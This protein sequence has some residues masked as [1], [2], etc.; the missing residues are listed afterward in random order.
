MST[1]NIGLNTSTSSNGTLLQI[2]GLASNLDTNAIINALLAIDK[3]PVTRLTNQQSGLKAL[4]T[5]LTG[6]QTTLQ[7]LAANAQA[8][9][10][11]GLWA[12]S[13]TV[14]SSDPTRVSASTSSGAGVGGYQVSVTQLANSAQR[15]FT[16]ASPAADETVSIDG[17]YSTTIKAGES[18][19][20][21]VNGINADSG[22]PVYAAA[23]DSNHVV[24]SYRQTGAH[25]APNYIVL[26]GDTQNVL[27]DTGADRAGQDAQYSID[28][29]ATQ[30]SS[31]NTV[32][33]A[34]AGVTLTFNGVTTTSGPVT[35]NV[36]APAPNSTSIQAAVKTFVDSYNSMIDQL[37][38]QL[39]EKPS[40]SDPTVGTL[41]GDSELTDLMSQLRAT[42]YNPIAGLS[43][44]ISSLSDIGITTGAPT[45]SATF[46]QNSVDGKLTID[47]TKLANAIQSNPSGVESLLQGFSQSFASIANAVAQPGG[48]LDARIQGDNSE[49]SD[50]GDQI[51]N[52]NA[53]IADRQTALQ[54]QFANL[55]ALLSQ[56]QA[57][58]SWLAGQINSLPVA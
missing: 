46:S 55:E 9:S 35:V 58:S 5:Q 24:L 6:I 51:G 53:I 21:F 27:T 40:T 19:Q 36:G 13:Q 23:T 15:T 41:Y 33:S 54:A 3:Q 43:S 18:I 1:S 28:G 7:T 2:T 8:L 22:S 31:S 39:T 47:S 45:G 56:N 37:N 17:G 32:T 44:G 29:G 49:I 30:T 4:N 50:L 26:S 10:D 42:I 25:T 57:Q 38:T 14:A 11:P 16:Y 12:N 34:I 52:L 48:S 20:D